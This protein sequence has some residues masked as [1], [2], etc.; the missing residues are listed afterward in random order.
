MTLK[1]TNKTLASITLILFIHS[2]CLQTVSK[3][4]TQD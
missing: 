3:T 1:S 2:C 4:T